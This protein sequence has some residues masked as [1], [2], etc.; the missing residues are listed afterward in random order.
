MNNAL[1]QDLLNH[2]VLWNGGRSDACGCIFLARARLALSFVDGTFHRGLSVAGD[3]VADV[4]PRRLR[5]VF[6]LT[7]L[8]CDV[9]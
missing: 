4:H 6:Q 7:K 8:F 2:I 5:A 1:V 9:G 3:A